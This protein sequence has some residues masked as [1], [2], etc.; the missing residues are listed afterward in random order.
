MSTFSSDIT[1]A[2]VFYL[3]KLRSLL[4]SLLSVL[5]ADDA[6][7]HDLFYPHVHIKRARRAFAATGRRATM[8]NHQGQGQP[9]LC[10][11]I[12]VPPGF[13]PSP[14]FRATRRISVGYRAGE[15]GA[16]RVKKEKK[17]EGGVGMNF[18]KEQRGWR[19]VKNK[20]A[21]IEKR[22]RGGCRWGT[23]SLLR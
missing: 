3:H 21:G 6:G 12:L 4:F 2:N 11:E 15:S 20:R 16:G 13:L 7:L 22:R 1:V 23:V 14:L 10:Q 18:K 8:R 19:R 5:V 9:V 17:E